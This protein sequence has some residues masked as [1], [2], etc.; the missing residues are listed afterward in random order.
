MSTT[1]QTAPSGQT[2]ILA[3]L[4]LE[5]RCEKAIDFYRQVFNARV[6]ML[7]RYKDSPVPPNPE[8]CAPT[9]LD[10]IMHATLRL[11]NATLYLSDGEANGTPKF[12]GFALSLTPPTPADGDR[13]FAG[14]SQGGKVIMP[15]DKTFFSPRFGMVTDRFGIMWMINVMAPPA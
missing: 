3:Y 1:T 8:M 15:M 5:G 6:D 13:Y 2:H 7:M 4:F 10:R 9:S 11:G 12:E 14:L